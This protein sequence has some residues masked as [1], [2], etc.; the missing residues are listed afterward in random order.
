MAG[1]GWRDGEKMQATV[2]NNNKNK[3]KDDPA[4]EVNEISKAVV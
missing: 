4:D 2:L 3:K 1:V